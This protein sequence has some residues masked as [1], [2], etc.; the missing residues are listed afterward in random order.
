MIRDTSSQDT[1]I[2]RPRRGRRLLLGGIVLAVVALVVAGAPQARRLLGTPN[3]VGADR[4][5]IDEVS[6]GPFGVHIRYP[7]YPCHANPTPR[8]CF[9]NGIEIQVG[10]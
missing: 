1:P 2:A 10:V 7:V 5:G 9:I 4:L 3:S 8:C 6:R